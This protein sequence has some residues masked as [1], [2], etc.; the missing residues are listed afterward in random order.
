VGPQV[1][2][3]PTTVSL[4]KRH[5]T[6]ELQWRYLCDAL[7]SHRFYFFLHLERQEHFF[8]EHFILPSLARPVSGRS[9]VLGGSTFVPSTE[10]LSAS[11]VVLFDAHLRVAEADNLCFSTRTLNIDGRLLRAAGGFEWF[12][13]CDLSAFVG[14]HYFFFWLLLTPSS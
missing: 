5:S 6:I 1:G 4:Q 11:G 12:V 3:E 9:F 8:F 13:E 10:R 7:A 2:L 14:S